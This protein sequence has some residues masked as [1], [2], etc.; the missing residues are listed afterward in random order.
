LQLGPGLVPADRSSRVET[1]YKQREGS[2]AAELKGNVVPPCS[3][4]NS[5]VSLDLGALELGE[6][7]GGGKMDALN[8]GGQARDTAQH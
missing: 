7:L 8:D 4:S 2:R 5:A 6:N 1:R 3:A